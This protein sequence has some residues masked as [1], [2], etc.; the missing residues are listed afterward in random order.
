LISEKGKKRKHAASC[1]YGTLWINV[2]D[3]KKEVKKK[4]KR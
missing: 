3:E 1:I 4:K 2:S